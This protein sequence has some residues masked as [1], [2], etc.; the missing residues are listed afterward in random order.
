[1]KA[2]VLFSGGVDS[3]TCLAIAVDKYGAD[4]VL[5]LSLYY[6]QKHSR[7]LEAAR[8]IAAH[9][10]VKHKELDLAL[11][12]ADSDCTLLKGSEGEIPKESYA[13]Q[14]EKTDGK[15]VSTYVPFRN[16]LFLA[17]AASIAL[18][19]GCE[20]IYYG[21]HSDD[22]AGNAYPD[23][24]SDFNDAINRAIYLGSGGEL[25]VTA[26]FIGM[27]KAQVIA[28]GLELGVPYELT[29]SCYEG[30]DKPCG[31]CGTCR[32][33]IA[34]FRANGIDDPAMKGE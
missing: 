34:A 24:S 1:M 29:W 4:E 23:C 20:E 2:L 17:S 3:T 21:A 10:G 16:G 25:R 9:Y 6:G 33:R 19:N 27:N 15:P 11:I 8:K 22:A 31:V 5:A 18:S 7:E 14:L 28:K 12:F 30:G 32:D 26:P 13:V